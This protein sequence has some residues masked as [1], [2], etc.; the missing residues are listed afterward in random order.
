MT[1]AEILDY[2]RSPEFA[3]RAEALDAR[4]DDG[5]VPSDE[6]IADA[7]GLP[8]EF[9]VAAVAIQGAQIGHFLH[10]GRLHA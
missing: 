10:G 7:L 2:M 1:R 3:E 9:V 6:D 8:L 5:F 4:L